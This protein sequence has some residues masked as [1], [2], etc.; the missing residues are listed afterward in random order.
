MVGRTR[1]EP[2]R[3][4]S[5]KHG[6]DAALLHFALH[7]TAISYVTSRVRAIVGQE[8]HQRVVELVQLLELGQEPAA[9]SSSTL[10]IIAA[11]R[12]SLSISASSLALESSARS[13]GPGHPAAACTAI[14]TTRAH[15]ETVR[16]AALRWQV[17]KEV[18]AGL[19]RRVDERHCLVE[20]NVC[21]IASR[22]NL[23][24]ITKRDGV[25]IAISVLT[26][27]G[28]LGQPAAAQDQ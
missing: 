11:M 14:A 5:P 8:D 4:A 28:R 22:L 21:A 25:G 16:A 20:I 13:G 26:R 27:F 12:A 2:R 19:Q 24:P 6:A 23:L 10:V 18:L 9:T 15:H 3:P 17:D 7:A 1:L